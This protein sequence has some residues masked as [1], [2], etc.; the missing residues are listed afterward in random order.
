MV[1]ATLRLKEGRLHPLGAASDEAGVNFALFSAH[2]QEV[3]LCL[4]DD[5][6]QH[7]IDGIVLPEHTDEVCHGHLPSARPGRNGRCVV[8]TSAEDAPAAG[9]YAGRASFPL[10]AHSSALFV[11]TRAD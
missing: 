8:S 4:F 2:A 10:E 3:E 1:K 6:G 11:G 5:H 9:Q 7:E